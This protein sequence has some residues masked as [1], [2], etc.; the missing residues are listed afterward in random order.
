LLSRSIA[1]W[2]LRRR[3]LSPFGACV[4]RRGGASAALLTDESAPD[5]HSL[6]RH[7]GLLYRPEEADWQAVTRHF[8]RPELVRLFD[9]LGQRA[10][11]VRRPALEIGERLAEHAGDGRPCL[12]FVLYGRRGSGKSLQMGHVASACRRRGWLLVTV[13]NAHL[14]MRHSREL[15]E[16]AHR[17]GMFDTAG[18]GCIWLRHFYAMNQEILPGLRVTKELSWNA[19]ESTP[20][21]SSWKEVIDYAL[22][23]P[24]YSCAAVQFLID[25]IKLGSLPMPTLVCFEVANC[26]WWHRSGIK[27]DAIRRTPLQGE[28]PPWRADITAKQLTLLDAFKQLLDSDWN[29]GAAVMS[30]SPQG[31]LFDR[32]REW[33][34]RKLLGDEGFAYLDPFVP[35]YVEPYGPAEMSNMLNWY[36]E[37][38]WLTSEAAATDAG[39]AELAFLSD[40]NAG[41]LLRIAGEW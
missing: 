3:Q 22:A 28:E 34:P 5:R 13:H 10:L 38:G 4:N 27:N 12:R 26:L 18:Y 8:C 14:W 39:R 40:G 25:E 17:P 32:L 7:V 41:E 29:N 24:R 15:H 21:G 11:M 2:L 19:K 16:S 23:R 37:S 35:V 9:T 30:V 1:N 36:T 6:D 31:A 33:M 20:A